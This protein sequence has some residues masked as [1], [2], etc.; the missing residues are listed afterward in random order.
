MSIPLASNSS[1]PSVLC[2]MLSTSLYLRRKIHSPNNSPAM[3]FSSLLNQIKH[4]TPPPEQKTQQQQPQPSTVK[5]SSIQT[6]SRPQIKLPLKVDP[7]VQ[8]LKE[9]RRLENEAKLE[10]K[11]A[12]N[13]KKPTHRKPSIK[14][15][16]SQS[17]KPTA[18]SNKISK[19]QPVK[20][21]SFAELMKQ[22]QQKTKT[23]TEDTKPPKIQRYQSK[24]KLFKPATTSPSSPPTYSLPSSKYVIRKEPPKPKPLAQPSAKLK[25]KLDARRK[26][27]QEYYDDEEE[28]DFIVNEED[29]GFDRD[30]IWKMFNKGKSRYTYNEDYDSSD[31]E[32]DGDE[33]FEEEEISSRNAKFEEKRESQLEKKRIE[34]KRKRLG[35]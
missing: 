3:S 29:E 25:A 31:M 15:S 1:V 26:S 12:A 10:A 13:I 2:S 30:E 27:K 32:A 6:D 19:P 5:K 9:L 17:I 22:G 20:R 16:I 28:N 23:L 8:R 24:T 4:R 7:A 35:R 11:K 21:L 34:E 18:N 33:I 14:P